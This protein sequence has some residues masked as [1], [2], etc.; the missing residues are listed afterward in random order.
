M[1]ESSA[2][3]TFLFTDIEGSTRLWEEAPETMRAALARHDAIARAAVEQHHGRVVKMTG[4]GTHAAFDDPQDAVRAALQMQLALAE[5][6]PA[7][8]VT[9]KLRCGIHAGVSERRDNDYFGTAV[10]R[11]ARIM[12]AAHGDQV[13]LS[14]VVVALAGELPMGAALRDLGRIRL[15]DL[16]S[17]ER[18]FQLL[19][20]RLRADFPPLRSLETTPNNLPQQLTSFVGRE[21][22][23]ARASVLLGRTRLLTVLGTGGLGKSRLALQI[24]A[25][26]LDDYPDGVWLV[27]LAAVADDRLVALSVA[28]VLGVKESPGHPIEDTLAKYVHDRRLLLILDNCEHL[29]DACAQ[30]ARCLLQAGAEMR[31]LTTSREALRITGETTLPMP[32][33][34]LPDGASPPTAA[35]LR[36]VD[37][38]KLFAERAAAANPDFNLD[39]ANA[40]AVAEICRR[41]DGIPLALEL[42]AA[43]MRSMPVERIAAR[44]DDRFRLLTEGDRT[45][46]KRQQTLHALIDWSHDLLTPAERV[47]FRRLAVFAGGWTLDAATDVGAGSKVAAVD[48]ADLMSRLAEKSLVARDAIGDRYHYLETIREY[49]GEQLE[50]EGET[51]A[52][53]LRHV[54]RYVALVE[55]ARPHLSGADPGTW[56]FRLDIE[57]E[58]LLA[59]HRYCDDVPEGG[60]LGMRFSNAIRR[61]WFERGLLG[62]G[63]RLTMEA[64]T[65]ISAQAPTALRASTLADAGQIAAYMGRYPEARG[66][67]EESIAIARQIGDRSRVEYAL[68]PLGLACIGM[69]DLVSAKGYMAE[70]LAL[71]REMGEHREIAAALNWAA[72]IARLEG[73]LEAA[74]PLYREVLALGREMPDIAAISLLNLAMVAIGR[75]DLARAQ[76]MLREVLVINDQY[77]S[78]PTGQSVLEVSAGLASANGDWPRALRLF[79]AAEAHAAITGLHRDATDEAFLA[80]LVARARASLDSENRVE[81]EASG[82]ALSYDA[83][84]AEARAWLASEG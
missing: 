15:R 29:V 81:A 1:S 44:L 10:N 34:A 80:P 82:R 51:A 76:E 75:G 67:L 52:V 41:L 58:N 70:A 45:A 68:Q 6:R 69:G 43:R 38:V 49:A 40:A 37:A 57:R 8:R 3:T 14:E 16:A 27:E 63:F 78:R 17:P 9:L 18:V 56:L 30:L 28:S 5:Q 26:A 65:R 31:I 55:A 71:A 36:E 39:D 77:G 46:L 79:S 83:A 22:E 59:A 12:S 4:D 20:P 60:D 23:L 47:L 62:L 50:R 32:T 2:V 7:G 53:R 66:F 25:E 73:D 24:A 61:Y 13:L 64:L 19:H 84:I 21:A 54:E 33:L 11:A 48:V 72:Q 42:A 35:A 74:E